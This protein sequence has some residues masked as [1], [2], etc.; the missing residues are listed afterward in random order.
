MKKLSIILIIAGILLAASPFI[1]QLYSTYNENRMI[2]EWL[3]SSSATEAEEEVQSTADPS[4]AYGQLSNVFSEEGNV[5]ETAAPAETP[6]IEAS[7]GPEATA[8]ASSKTEQT[9]IGVIKIKKIKVSVPIV[10]GVSNSNLRAGVGHIPGTAGIGQPGNCSLAGHRSYTFGRFF[11]RLDEL[12]I[13]DEFILVTKKQ[14][15][16]Y[17]IFSKTVVLPSDVS[18]LKGSKDE[19]IAT[20]ITCT[21]IYVATHRLIIQGRL[22]GTTSQQP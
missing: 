13:G 2:N 6:G 3:N 16:K 1:G 9:V 20:L 22:E 8:K 18:V 15:Y 11:N 14:E 21:P 10:E 7:T 17:K 4:Q 19:S 12:E 5:E